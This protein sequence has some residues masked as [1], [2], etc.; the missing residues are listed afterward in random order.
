MESIVDSDDSLIWDGW[1]VVNLKP[2]KDG[3]MSKDALRIDNSWYLQKRYEPSEQGW[4][5][6]DRFVR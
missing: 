5:L 4:N 3:L 1:T 6:P 2:V